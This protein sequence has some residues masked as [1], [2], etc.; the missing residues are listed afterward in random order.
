MNRYVVSYS[1]EE[2][3]PIGIVTNFKEAEVVAKTEMHARQE[4]KC[5]FIVNDIRKATIYSLTQ[6]NDGPGVYSDKYIYSKTKLKK[7]A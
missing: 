6:V 1:V 4:L 3:T 2:S 7:E 5:Y